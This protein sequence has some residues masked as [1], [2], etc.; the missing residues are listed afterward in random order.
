VSLTKEERGARRPQKRQYEVL[1][2]R[3]AE[4]PE[5][6][7]HAWTEAGPKGDLA[8]VSKGLNE[9]MTVLQSW[10]KRKFGNILRELDKAR[11]QLELLMLNGA[12]Q[13]EIRK[14]SDHLQE[15]LYR[16]EL[17]WLQRSRISW[18]K[19]GDRNTRFFTRKRIIGGRRTV[20]K[21]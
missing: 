4:L 19:E 10:S 13:Q 11:K 15:M 12:S 20:L 6:I 16:E 3:A 21:A 2:E 7:A 8:A 9:V 1:W 18:L 14:A 17:L 5:K